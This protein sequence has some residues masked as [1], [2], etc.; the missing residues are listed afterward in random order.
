MSQREIN[1][2]GNPGAPLKKSVTTNFHV[3]FTARSLAR[4]WASILVFQ[5]SPFTTAQGSA[6]LV[7]PQHPCS[8]RTAWRLDSRTWTLP[9]PVCG[10]SA[11]QGPTLISQVQGCF[12]KCY[13]GIS[14]PSQ[15]EAKPVT[16][17]HNWD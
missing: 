11:R 3:L 12:L 7:R 6:I 8:G 14:C 2:P 4:G 17:Y 9:R 5:S 10:A 1:V 15:H 16:I 13:M